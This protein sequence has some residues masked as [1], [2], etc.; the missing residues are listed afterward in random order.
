MGGAGTLK[1]VAN[2]PELF[3]DAACFSG[4]PTN[5][6]AVPPEG[7]PMSDILGCSLLAHHNS[8]DELLASEDNVWDRLVE[9]KD[10][11]PPIYASFGTADPYYE[12]CYL[13]FKRHAEVEG[14][15]I[16]FSETEG[17]VHDFWFWDP[18]LRR[19][20]EFWGI[21]K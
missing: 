13:P 6:R 16:T 8:M 5:F 4:C 19:A 12:C 11:L 3:A 9:N 17:A 10:R 7:D 2:N 15:P 20:L 18:E 1:F 14:L 21:A